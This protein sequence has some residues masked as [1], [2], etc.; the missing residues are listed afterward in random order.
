MNG[1][2]KR[3]KEVQ[4]SDRKCGAEGGGGLYKLIEK[5]ITFLAPGPRNTT[6]FWYPTSSLMKR[7]K[8]AG[9]GKAI[10]GVHG[11]NGELVSF[12]T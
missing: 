9:G 3:A 8:N 6:S 11:S 4:P 1:E 5:R 2:E 12:H 7:V 10:F